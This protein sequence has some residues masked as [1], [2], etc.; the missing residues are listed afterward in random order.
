M[1]LSALVMRKARSPAVCRCCGQTKS[2]VVRE[3]QMSVKRYCAHRAS[4]YFGIGGSNFTTQ[5]ISD[6]VRAL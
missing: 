4:N 6:S 3:G 5:K 2:E 1:A